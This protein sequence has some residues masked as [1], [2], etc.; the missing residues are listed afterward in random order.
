MHPPQRDKDRDRDTRRRQ[1]DKEDKRNDT[2]EASESGL[3]GSTRL[4]VR[5]GQAAGGTGAELVASTVVQ[6]PGTDD[7]Q[8]GDSSTGAQRA[9]GF[10]Y[11]KITGGGQPGGLA[12]A[13]F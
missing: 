7:D 12:G 2:R 13:Y 8:S 11:T 6:G 3:T 1:K 9:E 10:P 4:R 5:E